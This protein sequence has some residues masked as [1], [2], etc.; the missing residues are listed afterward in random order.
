[1]PGNGAQSRFPPLTTL[2]KLLRQNMRDAIVRARPEWSPLNGMKMSW[3]LIRLPPSAQRNLA[4]LLLDAAK[5]AGE[6]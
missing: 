2:Q 1:M 6:G 3:A 4:R 5:A